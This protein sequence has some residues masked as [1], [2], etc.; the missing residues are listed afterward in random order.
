MGKKHFT[1]NEVVPNIL[2]Q[3]KSAC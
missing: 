2:L 1:T 3:L